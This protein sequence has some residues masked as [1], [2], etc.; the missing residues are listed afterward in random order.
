MWL[1][2]VLPEIKYPLQLPPKG[3]Y[4]F[5]EFILLKGCSIFLLYAVSKN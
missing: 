1:E 2:G 4:N 3:A 5:F